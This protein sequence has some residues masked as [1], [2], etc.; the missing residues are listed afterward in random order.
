MHDLGQDVRFALRTREIG[1]RM[2]LGAERRA[3]FTLVLRE[4][5]LLAAIGVALGLPAATASADSSRASCTG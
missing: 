4:V 2:A 1:V 5:A 3:V